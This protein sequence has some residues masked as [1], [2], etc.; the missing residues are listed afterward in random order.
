MLSTSPNLCL[1]VA[2]NWIVF[3]LPD[4]SLY[5]W[6]T[7]PILSRP[8]RKASDNTYHCSAFSLNIQRVSFSTLRSTSFF[9]M[10]TLQ[11]T[12]W[13]DSFVYSFLYWETAKVPP[14]RRVLLHNSSLHISYDLMLEFLYIY[15]E[16]LVQNDFA[17][18]Q[19]PPE[20]SFKRFY[21]IRFSGSRPCAR[22]QKTATCQVN[23]WWPLSVAGF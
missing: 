12:A 13:V 3:A 17:F 21:R 18:W 19:I 6:Y 7:P 9:L 14:P 5:P 16:L 20:C 15:K 8:C 2:A 4:F 11:K 23:A 10:T 22:K 1:A